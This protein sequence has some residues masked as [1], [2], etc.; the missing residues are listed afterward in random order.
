MSSTVRRPA[1]TPAGG[2]FAGR[3]GSTPEFALSGDPSIDELLARTA[4]GELV[5]LDRGDGSLCFIDATPVADGDVFGDIEWGDDAESTEVFGFRAYRQLDDDE[6]SWEVV[7]VVYGKCRDDAGEPF[8]S[9]AVFTVFCSDPIRPWDS[10]TGSDHEYA[11]TKGYTD[12]QA[13]R[14]ARE[15]IA[16]ILAD[17]SNPDSDIFG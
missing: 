9:R 6:G 12:G 10:T 3:T 8:L 2:Q 4:T 11:D 1:G 5:R 17:P 7:D 15:E 16:A 14:E 13:E